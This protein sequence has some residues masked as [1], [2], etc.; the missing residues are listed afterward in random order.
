VVVSK[1]SPAIEKP[2]PNEW[3]FCLLGYITPLD[4]QLMYMTDEILLPQD[5]HQRLGERF[6]EV[7]V[8]HIKQMC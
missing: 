5:V 4:F 8:A 2:A 3:A 1:A 7:G 6:V